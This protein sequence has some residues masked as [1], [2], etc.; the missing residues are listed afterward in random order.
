MSPDGDKWLYLK[1]VVTDGHHNYAVTYTD[2]ESLCEIHTIRNPFEIDFYHT[3]AILSKYDNSLRNMPLSWTQYEINGAP[4]KSWDVWIK[5][6]NECDEEYTIKYDI[7]FTF[8]LNQCVNFKDVEEEDWCCVQFKDQTASDDCISF[9]C[10]GDCEPNE[11][12]AHLYG[13]LIN[14][15]IVWCCDI[16]GFAIQPKDEIISKYFAT[17]NGFE[18]KI[19]DKRNNPQY[20]AKFLTPIQYPNNDPHYSYV[21]RTYTWPHNGY[22]LA[23]DTV[24]FDNYFNSLYSMAATMDELWCD[25][26]WKNM[27]HESIKNFDWTYTK[28]YEEGEEIDNILGGT[29]MQNVLR[30]WGRTFDDIKRY[31]DAISLKNCITYDDR[32]NVSN[33][34]LSDKAELLGWEAYSTKITDKDNDYLTNAYVKSLDKLPNRWGEDAIVEHD[35]WFYTKTPNSVS[36]NVVDNEFMRNLVLNTGDIFRT[37]GTK[38]G[39]EKVL[40]LFGIGDDEITFEE[41]YYTVIPKLRDEM[42]NFIDLTWTHRTWMNMFRLRIVVVLRNM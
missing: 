8:N 34:E 5:P 3:D 25:N 24:G 11:K 2:N 13:I 12:V 10:A 37:K 7:R 41:R 35:K 16:D 40:A 22:C 14:R 38:H 27:T 20:T 1:K 4:L 19:L 17:L 30:I 21:E 29:R 6:Y 23:V 28:Q 31:V 18:A 15:K 36:Q 9:G 42:F 32:M 33:A 26:L 39:I